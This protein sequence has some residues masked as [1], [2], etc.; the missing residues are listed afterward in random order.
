[1]MRA[2]RL[3]VV[4]AALT[5]PVQAFAGPQVPLKGS[6]VGGFTLTPGGVCASGWF[7]VDINGAGNA[8]HLGRY[9]YGAIECFNPTTGAFAG[10]FT[11]TAANGDKVDGT[12]AGQVSATLDPNVAAYSEQAIVTGG[13]GRFA[14]ATGTLEI[15]GL[16][17]L[18][19][20]EYSQTLSGDLTSPGAAN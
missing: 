18:A 9:T 16:A 19:T 2:V 10:S 11:L 4:L 8:T 20:G 12:Y 7:Q 13:T 5:L 3:L 15:N 17:N 14:G 1:M 6:D